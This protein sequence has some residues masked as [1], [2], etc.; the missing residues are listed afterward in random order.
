MILFFVGT[1]GKATWGAVEREKRL[2]G[3]TQGAC[4]GRVALYLTLLA[5]LA[6][7]IDV[8]FLSA[9]KHGSG[10]RLPSATVLLAGTMADTQ[11]HLD[12]P[13][14]VAGLIVG[15]NGATIN[16]IKKVMQ[17]PPLPAA[18]FPRTSAPR[19]HD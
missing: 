18:R 15:R 10:D 14:A 7:P 13:T 9:A 11:T 19:S 6:L 12:L 1:V 8:S 17:H 16:N 3:D 4:G 2:C 5:A